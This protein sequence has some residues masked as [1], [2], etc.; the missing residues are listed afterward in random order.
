MGEIRTALNRNRR[1][2]IFAA[3][4]WFDLTVPYFAT[5]YAMNHVAVDP[6]FAGNIR[7]KFFAGGHM[8]YTSSENLEEFAGEMTRFF[9]G[10]TGA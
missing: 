6:E 4:G 5:S 3:A 1:L 7:V 9:K 8:F 2:K 10:L